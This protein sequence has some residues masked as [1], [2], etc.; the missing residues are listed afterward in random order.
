MT[1]PRIELTRV[2]F[3]PGHARP[4]GSL[5]P[6]LVRDGA[7]RLTGDVRMVE[8]SKD[9][10]RWRRIVAQHVR[11]LGWPI[12]ADGPVAVAMT[13]WFPPPRGEHGR[14]A[15]GG[16]IG[17]LDKL[18]RNVLDALDAKKEGAGAYADDRQVAYLHEPLKYYALPAERIGLG[19][20]V[21]PL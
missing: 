2:A 5:K 16:E 13:F 3:I 20:R 8:S 15:I 4:K 18:V 17:D 14:Y 9:G 1:A 10:P 19:L 11:A 21:W 7:G 6:Q 12:I